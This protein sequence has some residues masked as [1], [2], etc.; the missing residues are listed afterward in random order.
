M[1]KR[2]LII[3]PHPDDET[4]GCGGTILKH[5]NEGDE[6]FWLI[7]TNIFP[8]IH[9]SP[10]VVKIRNKEIDK[11]FHS[12]GFSK[13]FNLELPP[14][15]LDKFS[16]TSLVSLIGNVINEVGPSIIYIN[17]YSDI[18]SDHRRVFD[19]AY[20]CTKHFRYPTVQK[21]LL[22]ETLS[23]TEYSPPIS[24]F[25]FTPNV[26]IDVTPFIEKKLSIMKIY[27][28]EMMPDNLPRSSSSIL[29][30]NRFRGSRIGVKYAEAFMLLIDIV[31]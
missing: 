18:H 21:V 15:E 22:Y 5:V 27:K 26:F 12:Y 7:I 31:K 23:E 25:Q 4:L 16:L 10:E 11:V 1:K 13:I 9:W 19:A 6:V 14:S 28:S 17:N 24:T 30:L 3:A 2:I 20:S 8:S 29:A